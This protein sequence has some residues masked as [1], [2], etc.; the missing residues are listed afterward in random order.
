MKR[1]TR[2]WIA[3]ALLMTAAGAASA[4]TVK[5]NYQEPDKFM[6]MPAWEKDRNFVLKEFTEHFQRVA[7]K[8]PANQ[9][10]NVTVTDIDLAGRVEPSR[11]TINDIRVLRGQADWPTMQLQYTLEE[12]GKVIASGSSNLKNMVYLE[13][14]NRYASGDTLRYEKPMID[15]WFKDTFGTPAQLSKK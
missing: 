5:V 2:F 12:G 13:G 14:I 4:G 3:A 11:R 6:D 1:Q 15:D 8:L 7:K 9:H 10:L